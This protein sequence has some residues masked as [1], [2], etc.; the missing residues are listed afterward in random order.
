MTFLSN[1]SNT[2]LIPFQIKKHLWCVFDLIVVNLGLLFF[3]LSNV[4]LLL[5]DVRIEM[6]MLR[7]N[8]N[9]Y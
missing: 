7:L 4:G 3:V 5:N 8:D 1:I 2:K 9:K 6:L